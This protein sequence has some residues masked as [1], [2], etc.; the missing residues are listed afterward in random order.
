MKCE[1]IDFDDLLDADDDIDTDNQEIAKHLESC[2]HCQGRMARLAADAEQWDEAQHWLTIGRVKEPEYAESLSARERWKRPMAWNEAMAQSILSTASHPEMLGR[3]GRYDVER[4]IGS[5][6]MGV[7]FKAYDTELNRP[8]AIKLLAP[9]LASSGAAR[10]RFA[11]EARAA[12]AVVDDHVV[13]IHNVETDDKH[14]FLVMKYIAGGSLQQRLDRDGPL[15]VCEV[16]R[17]GMHT[18]KGLAAAHEQGLI[19]RDVKPSNILLDEGVDRALLTDFGLAR[20][21]DDASLTRSG[22][23]PGTPHYMSPEQVR[24]EAIDARSDL[25][26][27]GCV[28]Y[29]MCSGHPP[30]RS[31]TSYA[32]LRR[33]TDDTPRPICESNPEIPTW[34][35]QIVMKLLAKTADERFQSADQIAELLGNCLAHIQQPSITPLPKQVAVLAAGRSRIPPVFKFIAATT[36]AFSVIFAAVLIVLELNKGKLTIESNVD[37]VPIRIMKDG[38]TVERLTVHQSGDTVRVAAGNYVVLIDGPTE[39]LTVKGGEVSL[40]RGGNEIVKIIHSAVQPEVSN[41]PM[42]EVQF[43]LGESRFVTGD[44]IEIQSVTSTGKGLEVGAKVTVKGSYTL[45]SIETADLGFY[46]TVTLEPGDQF[47][48]I[49]IQSSQTMHAKKGTHPFTLSTLITTVGSTHLSFYQSKTGEGLGG[50]YFSAK[51]NL[52][53]VTESLPRAEPSLEIDHGATTGNLLNGTW[54]IELLSPGKAKRLGFAAFAGTTGMIASLV[55]GTEPLGFTYDIQPHDRQLWIDIYASSGADNGGP[56]LWQGVVEVNRSSITLCFAREDQIK[57]YGRPASIED[58]HPNVFVKVTFIKR[59]TGTANRR[60]ESQSTF[61]ETEAQA[62]LYSVPRGESDAA[63]VK[64]LQALSEDDGNHAVWPDYG[65]EFGEA[66]NGVEQEGTSASADPAEASDKKASTVVPLDIHDD[67]NNSTELDREIQQVLS[68]IAALNQREDLG[69]LSSRSVRWGFELKSL[70]SYGP[71]A[72]PFIVRELDQTRDDRMIATLAFALRAIGDKRGVPALIRAIPRSE[73]HMNKGNWIQ[74][75]SI[76]DAEL[77]SFF[78]QHDFNGH[79]NVIGC[80][81]PPT[82]LSWALTVLTGQDFAVSR[83]SGLGMPKQVYLQRKLLHRDADRWAQWWD[84]NSVELV[85][86][87]AYT[88][89]NL[90]PMNMNEPALVD[91]DEVLA[92]APF[93]GGGSFQLQA[94]QV[95]PDANEPV[96]VTFLDLDTG[97]SGPIPE[98]WRG[99]QLSE[100][101]RVDIFSWA[102]QEGYDIACDQS[103]WDSGGGHYLLRG[104]GLEAWQLNE[105]RWESQSDYASLNGLTKDGKKIRGDWLIPFSEEK[106]AFDPKAMAPFLVVTREGSPALLYVGAEITDNASSDRIHQPDDLF[107]PTGFVVG[108]KLAVKLLEPMVSVEPMGSRSRSSVSQ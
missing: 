3:I 78:R 96:R 99:K 40:R 27:L 102:E 91:P 43:I 100:A 98:V 1:T 6:G 88:V 38:E 30:F 36:I 63:L 70:V 69:L 20:A 101:D 68:R 45:K 47:V 29:A 55:D 62:L 86:D 84:A 17:I 94:L 25:F 77:V 4:L 72:V 28:L 51:H 82:E 64:E 95:R 16:L 105:R 12:A 49:P 7:V 97:Q 46:S 107:R 81:D 106:H 87:A 9:Y 10:N 57:G 18:A 92:T 90:P 23:H 67:E 8:V 21:T 37:G 35:E 73:G 93:G 85:D 33:I 13:P 39:E 89:T 42:K 74:S 15:E 104:I 34:L 31:E 108:R 56:S 83:I 26:G 5:G 53:D 50:V 65:N 19:H 59:T 44:H 80:S 24:G 41:V 54:E 58:A 79:G 71:D 76:I 14:P 48:P 2:T 32:V 60:S 103:D 11:R 22:F 61:S 52:E 75:A 66:A